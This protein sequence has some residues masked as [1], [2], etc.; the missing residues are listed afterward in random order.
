MA[1]M[2]VVRRRL[3]KGATALPVATLGGCVVAPYGPYYRPT[4]EHPGATYKG[5][6]CN[7]VAG[8]K[9]VI[10][11]PL[12]PGVLLSA[13]AQREYAERERAELPLRVTLD[14]PP[15]SPVRFAGRELR[16]VEQG[17]GRTIGGATRM[18]AF[19]Y[20]T[21]SPDSWIDPIRV[22]PGGAEGTPL[23]DQA[24]YG[25]ATVRVSLEPASCRTG[26]SSTDWRCC[27]TAADSAC[28]RSR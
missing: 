12:A 5:A 1:D 11:L 23:D 28:P 8:P 25:N 15:A 6:W 20:A 10:E 17:S 26:S 2:S 24:P 18:R 27:A 16:V 21:L 3:L 7:G 14:V 4:A 9:A 19:R 13:R 22:R